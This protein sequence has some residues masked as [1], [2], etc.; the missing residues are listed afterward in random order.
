MIALDQS[1]KGSE[2]TLVHVHVSF[3]MFG[4][5]KFLVGKI[6]ICPANAMMKVLMTLRNI[7]RIMA[8][9]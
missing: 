9:K 8:T 5:A 2:V 6:S 7:N 4:G 1:L 3:L